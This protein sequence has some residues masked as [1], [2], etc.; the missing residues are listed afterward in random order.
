MDEGKCI[1]CEIVTDNVINE[2]MVRSYGFSK[3]YMCDDCISKSKEFQKRLEGLFEKYKDDLE[4]L[5][6]E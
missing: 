5:T 2:S 4:R 3:A 1:Y 6:K